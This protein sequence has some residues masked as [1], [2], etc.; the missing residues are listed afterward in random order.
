MRAQTNP[1][2]ME[3]LISQDPAVAAAIVFGHGRFQNGVLLQPREPFDP[4]DARSLE[5]FRDRVWCVRFLACE[6]RRE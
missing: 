6:A 1:V 4:A 2:P 3:A 5:A